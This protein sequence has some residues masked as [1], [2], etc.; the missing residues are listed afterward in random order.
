MACSTSLTSAAH[1]THKTIKVLRI[2][3]NQSTCI[4]AQCDTTFMVWHSYMNT[5]SIKAS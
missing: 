3:A 1:N 5:V 2:G 4:G